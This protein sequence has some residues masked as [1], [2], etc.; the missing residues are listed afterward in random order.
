M[1]STLLG[2][3]RTHTNK[4]IPNLKLWLLS[5]LTPIQTLK[6]MNPSDSTP[7]PPSWFPHTIHIWHHTPILNTLTMPAPPLPMW[8]PK[9]LAALLK[10]EYIQLYRDTTTYHHQTNGHLEPLV[11]LH[12]QIPSLPPLLEIFTN[13]HQ[14][15][16]N[17][18]QKFD[19]FLSSQMSSNMSQE[20][21]NFGWG[22]SY[23]AMWHYTA[24]WGHIV[25][26]TVTQKTGSHLAIFS[27]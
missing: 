20:H 4:P 6:T 22:S 11:K 26:H 3:T 27:L 13:K 14:E 8:N 25:P 9:D 7:V 16:L 10:E 15:T 21:K 12:T 17:L 18:S 24:P 5:N 2:T 1:S 19:P 23:R